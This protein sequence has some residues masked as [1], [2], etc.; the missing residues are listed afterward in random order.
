MKR[1][2]N[3]LPYLSVVLLCGCDTVAEISFDNEQVIEIAPQ[4]LVSSK[5]DA[6]D[7]ADAVLRFNVL[8][9]LDKRLV[10]GH[11][12]SNM[13]EGILPGKTFAASNIQFSEAWLFEVGSD[14]N[15]VTCTSASDC[16]QGASCLSVDQMGLS[17]YY[18]APGTYC[19][20]PAN[21]KI[22]G[23][24]QFVHYSAAPIDAEGVV[25]QN[26]NGRSISFMF[27]NSATLDGSDVD[28]AAN[29]ETAS[30]PWQ[31]R[32][33]GLSSF[34]D[35]LTYDG[36]SGAYEFSMH[37]ANGVGS[38][39]VYA[40][41]S[42]WLKTIAQWK[43]NV[44]DKFPTP[45]GASPIWEAVLASAEMLIDSANTAYSRTLVAFTDGAPNESSAESKNEFVKRIGSSTTVGLSWLDYT[46]E[47][48]GPTYSYAESV[49]LQCGSY[50]HFH[51]ASQ[52]PVIMRRLALATESW[53]DIGISFGADLESGHLYKLATLFVVT[54]GD[55]AASFA[56]QRKL[57]NQAVLDERFV[58]VK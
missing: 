48:T 20:V 55:G 21:I 17:E 30:D 40:A 9:S 1:L 53:W 41:T 5:C 44:M 45:S 18:Y 7:G 54:A 24:P 46:P 34:F 33:V 19:V 49:A 4:G 43:A 27:D 29:D 8:T 28:G 11:H 2:I 26:L 12:L 57:D 35:A 15:D 31:Y 16:T 51:A 22:I 58:V 14:G 25:S 13:E 6:F 32:R 37:F 50:Y 10:P 56:A 36:V 23:Q 47:G 3:F 42:R 39:G 52:I 38:N